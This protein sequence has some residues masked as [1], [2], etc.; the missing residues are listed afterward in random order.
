ME[1]PLTTI[2]VR[3]I[4][5]H[6]TDMVMT[7]CA[8]GLSIKSESFMSKKMD[9]PHAKHVESFNTTLWLLIYTTVVFRFL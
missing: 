8:C 3:H 7:L 6:H 4:N 1:L 9:F 2:L 5:R